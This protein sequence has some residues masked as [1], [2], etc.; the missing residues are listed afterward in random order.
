MRKSEM[1]SIVLN[2]VS[3]EME[4]TPEQI[5]SG[6]KCQEIVDA[7]YIVVHFS[8]RCGIYISD[9]AR[10]MNFSRRAIEKMLS[11]FDERRKFSH[12]LF[13]IQYEL[14]AKKLR[15]ACVPFH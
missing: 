9:I 1:F 2:I 13:D 8:R 10:M 7:R 11:N 3:E 14:I 15:I 5:L 6:S 4:L 12:H